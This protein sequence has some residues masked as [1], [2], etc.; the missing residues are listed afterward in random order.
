MITNRDQ[1][2]VRW[3]QYTV[4]S[5][6]N[7]HRQLLSVFIF[8]KSGDKMVFFYSPADLTSIL[9]MQRIRNVR[10]VQFFVFI[11]VHVPL[12]TRLSAKTNEQ[13]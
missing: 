8:H 11:S 10:D 5:M 4:V 9:N 2:P 7:S 1:W 13:G 12:Y 3:M 6:C